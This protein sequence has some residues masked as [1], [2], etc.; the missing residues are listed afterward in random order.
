MKEGI[1]VNCGACGRSFDS[2]AVKLKERKKPDGITEVYYLCPFCRKEYIVC[3]HNAETK[4]LQKAITLADRSGQI[5]KARKLRL[6]L[7][8]RLDEL[9]NK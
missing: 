1:K 9:N 7:K 8:K 6:L 4:R 2:Y 5:E 3:L